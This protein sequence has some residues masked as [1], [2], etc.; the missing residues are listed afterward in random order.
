ML[1]ELAWGVVP[2]ALLRKVKIRFDWGQ[3]LLGEL[4]FYM[5]N[6][7]AKQAFWMGDMAGSKT[8]SCHPSPATLC[9]AW[10]PCSCSVPSLNSGLFVLFSGS[11]DPTRHKVP[12][13]Q[14]PFYCHGL[15]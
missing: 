15:L 9:L 12:Q 13:P 7:R 11:Q 1:C 2:S 10:P 5:G 8:S 4:E 3:R 14:M 6:S